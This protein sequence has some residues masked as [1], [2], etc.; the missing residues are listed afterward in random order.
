[1]TISLKLSIFCVLIVFFISIS[2]LITIDNYEINQLVNVDGKISQLS[3][4]VNSFKKLKPRIN[5][6][7]EY[8]KDGNKEWRRII[9]IQFKRGGYLLLLSDEIGNKSIS[10][11]SYFIGKVNL[12]E[13]LL[14]VHK[15]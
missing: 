8:Y 1:M 5:S 13:R 12:W 2:F 4:S 3:L 11:I 6:W 9:D 10:I 7:F 14:G 15:L